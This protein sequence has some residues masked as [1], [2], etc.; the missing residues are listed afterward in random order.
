MRL[1]AYFDAYR[2]WCTVHALLFDSSMAWNAIL[3]CDKGSVS[4]PCWPHFKI[5]ESNYSWHWILGMYNGDNNVIFL[6]SLW[7]Y[8]VLMIN[9]RICSGS[10]HEPLT[11]VSIMRLNTLQYHITTLQNRWFIHLSPRHTDQIYS[12]EKNTTGKTFN[13]MNWIFSK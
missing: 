1:L 4:H 8:L 9:E 5:I 10:T 11:I 7:L 12:C 13:R 6:L 2:V 3:R